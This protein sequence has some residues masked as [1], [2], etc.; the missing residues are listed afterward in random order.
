MP[1]SRPSDGIVAR[2]PLV[3][4]MGQRILGSDPYRPSEFAR[5]WGV[6]CTNDFESAID[7]VYS[8]SEAGRAQQQMLD[9]SFF[10]KI[11]LDPS[12]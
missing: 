10:G 3:L 1:Y 5:C 9:S 7:T 2:S 4:P 8:L 11:L 6:F 12:R